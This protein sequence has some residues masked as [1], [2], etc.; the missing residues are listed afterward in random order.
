MPE[1]EDPD[2]VRLQER[3]T[4][5]GERLAGLERRLDGMAQKAWWIITVGIAW[6]AEQV[7]SLIS[8]GGH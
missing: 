2:V 4:A 8:K 5:M 1:D 6:A 7:F 3:F